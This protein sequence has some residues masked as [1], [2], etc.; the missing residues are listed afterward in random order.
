MRLLLY[1]GALLIT[2]LIAIGF[3]WAV[4]HYRARPGPAQVAGDPRLS[5]R[6]AAHLAR[7]A[8]RDFRALTIDQQ[9]VLRDDLSAATST[10]DV[11]AREHVNATSVLC[12]GE[13]HEDAIRAF[14]GREVLSRI[15]YQVLML[16]TSQ[17]QLQA[18]LA[19]FDDGQSVTLL[20]A[21]LNGILNAA[22]THRPAVKIIAID[23]YQASRHSSARTLS[24]RESSLVA[25]IRAEWRPGRRHAILFGALHCRAQ[26]G[27]MMHRL[28]QQDARIRRAGI[29]GAVV[30]ARYREASAQVLMY[31]LEEIGLGREIVV[32]PQISLFPKLIQQWLPITA[33]ALAG[34]DSAIMFDDRATT[35]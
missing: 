33:D 27:W 1:V 5:F 10:L 23:E 25:R 2:A 8:V 12:L 17:A 18:M 13:R 11:W 14:I 31:L 32:I 28:A 35:Q 24:N 29:K 34:Y 3:G 22:R 4:E 30:L 19:R 26:S 16:E 21:S 7:S 9:R 6:P 15:D 20:D